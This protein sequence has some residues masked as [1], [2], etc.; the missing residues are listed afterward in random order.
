MLVLR[1]YT[2]IDTRSICL[3]FIYSSSIERLPSASGGIKLPIFAVHIRSRLVT[4]FVQMISYRLAFPY[5]ITYT[6]IVHESS[7]LF[8][9]S[10]SHFTQ[11]VVF[12][13]TK[14]KVL[15]YRFWPI[16]CL[17]REF[18]CWDE[19]GT[20]WYPFIHFMGHFELIIIVLIYAIDGSIACCVF[21]QLVQYCLYSSAPPFRLSFN[22]NGGPDCI[23]AWGRVSSA[24]WL[25]QFLLCGGN[26]V[27]V[28]HTFELILI[29][30]RFS[31][32]FWLLKVFHC[33]VFQKK[34]LVFLS[35]LTQSMNASVTNKSE[36][37]FRSPPSSSILESVDE[38]SPASIFTIILWQFFFHIRENRIQFWSPVYSPTLLTFGFNLDFVFV[39]VVGILLYRD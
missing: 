32:I 35:V 34:I 27:C 38:L 16:N 31:E 25:T 7:D 6:Q 26:C 28:P 37:G 39:V 18:V 24:K 33:C 21:H 3:P 29:L 10:K 1:S 4:M 22:K 11:Y 30:T 14:K 9:Q 13:S 17:A 20:K 5:S 23:T 36:I 19:N 2:T 15:R 12:L 8:A